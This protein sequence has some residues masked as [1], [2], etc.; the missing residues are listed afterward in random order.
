MLLRIAETTYAEHVSAVRSY[1]YDVSKSVANPQLLEIANRTYVDEVIESD[2]DKYLNLI[3]AGH[4]RMSAAKLAEIPI[5]W[6]KLQLKSTSFLKKVEIAEEEATEAI[7]RNLWHA[8]K[9]GERW[10][11]EMWLKKRNKTRWGDDPAVIKHEGTVVQ[12]ISASRIAEQISDIQNVL[13]QRIQNEN[14]LELEGLEDDN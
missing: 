9:N 6:I 14:I 2:E 4:G 13:N 8:A 11:I 5:D 12:E 10:A 7:E 1:V 3:R